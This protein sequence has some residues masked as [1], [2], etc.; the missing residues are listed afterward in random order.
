MNITT[1]KSRVNTRK[2][3]LEV[4]FFRPSICTYLIS[5]FVYD[6][7]EILF[8]CKIELLDTQYDHLGMGPEVDLKG[9]GIGSD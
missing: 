7:F 9:T 1:F 8:L 6:F 3:S 2:E 5:M 4:T